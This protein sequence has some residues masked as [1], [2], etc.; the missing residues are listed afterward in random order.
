MHSPGMRAPP[1]SHEPHRPPGAAGSAGTQNG[2]RREAGGAK[3]KG[4]RGGK[5]S[6]GRSGSPVAVPG[7]SSSPQAVGVAP[8]GVAETPPS[9]SWSVPNNVSG[10]NWYETKCHCHIICV[11]F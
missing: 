8:V 5:R 7:E 10:C 6:P 3:G 4:R 9:R 2:E 11:T 1:V